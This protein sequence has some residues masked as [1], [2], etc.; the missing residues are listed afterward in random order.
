MILR[1][2][3]AVVGAVVL[4]VAGGCA[5]EGE[6]AEAPREYS[7]PMMGTYATIVVR[8][9]GADAALA[10]AKEAM[11]EVNGQ[12]SN[13]IV[14]SDVSRLNK[15]AGSGEFVPVG[16]H[17]ACMLRE[18]LKYFRD[19]GGAF[20]PAIGPL[21]EAWGFFR[22][23][24]RGVVA[25][26]PEESVIVE[27]LPR[28]DFAAIE[29]RGDAEARLPAA[30]MVLDFGA[31]AKGYAVDVVYDRLAAAGHGAYIVNLGGN[32]RC[33][34]RRNG[35]GD[36]WRV[37][38]RNP[39]AALE[40]EPLG[41]LTLCDGM[42]VATSGDYEQFVEYDGKRYSHIIDGRT[43]YPARGVAQ[44]TVVAPTALEADALSTTCFVLGLEASRAVLEKHPGS[45]AL[46]VLVDDA[47]EMTFEAAGDFM[48]WFKYR[49]AANGK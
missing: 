33:A 15:G 29:M 35:A 10:T 6:K 36:P 26:P 1:S 44:V 40:D 41:T 49:E 32:M 38:V 48:R 37:A 11:E 20:N 47:G 7:W 9:G 28:C 30:G 43:G 25:A 24:S 21:V 19:S 5:R 13:F 22:G 8:G 17:T 18:S 16:A 45:G 31:I 46:F 12:L 23:R 39:R 42:A 4:M 3:F 2:R 27:T 34:G 14:E